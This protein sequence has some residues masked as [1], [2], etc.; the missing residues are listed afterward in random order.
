MNRFYLVLCLAIAF[1]SGCKQ[2]PFE[3]E[4]TAKKI[5]TLKRKDVSDIQWTRVWAG[6]QVYETYCS[7]CHGLKGDGKGPA[8]AMLSVMP[9]NF[10]KA[11]FK[12]IS[13]PAGSL[14]ADADLHRTLLRGIPR[15]SMPSWA[16]LPETDRANVIEYIKTFSERWQTSPPPNALSFGNPPQWLGSAQSIAK[17]KITYAKMGCANCHGET[18]L[19]DGH[20]AAELKDAEDHPIQPFNFREGQLK[21][22]TRVEDIYRTFYTGLAGTPMPAFGGVLSD[23]D[24]WHLVSYVVYLMGKTNVKENDL[25]NAKI[26]SVKIK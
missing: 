7:G 17:G 15:T 10:T 23:E 14:P 24:N 13:T 20:S 3:E 26:D 21:G 5:N 4:S 9:R 25:V 11:M 8:N 16:M 18:G 1:L 2:T 19:G 12:F 6:K 22:G